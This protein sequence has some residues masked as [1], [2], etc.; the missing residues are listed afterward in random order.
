MK[1]NAVYSLLCIPHRQVCCWL[2]LATE[3]GENQVSCLIP[4]LIAAGGTKDCLWW[5][6][7]TE[8][9]RELVKQQTKNG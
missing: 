1:V 5:Y 7:G 3:N 8:T 4:Q 9:E 2:L 6:L